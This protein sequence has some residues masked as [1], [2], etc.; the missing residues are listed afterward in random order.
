MNSN[1]CISVIVT[2]NPTPPLTPRSR[3]FHP[4]G[5][6]AA[7]QL[8]YTAA[9]PRLASEL[10]RSGPFTGIVYDFDLGC[11]VPRWLTVEPAGFGTIVS[12]RTHR[13]EFLVSAEARVAMNPSGTW[14]YASDLDPN[15]PLLSCRLARHSQGYVY[16]SH[17]NRTTSGELLHRMVARDVNGAD[18]SNGRVVHHKDGDKLNNRPCNLQV[19]PSQSEHMKHHHATGEHAYREGRPSKSKRRSHDRRKASG[20]RKAVPGS[21]DRHL[22]FESACLVQDSGYASQPMAPLPSARISSAVLSTNPELLR[23]LGGVPSAF[24]RRRIK[25]QHL[26]A[27]PSPNK[28]HSGDLSEAHSSFGCASFC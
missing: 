15:M 27:Q 23:S 21:S 1:P 18:I 10:A 3:G 17:R 28:G 12:V 7:R 26:T 20:D 4:T 19:F 11:Y 22:A 5:G 2:Y 13:G 8:I 14:R 6:I 25:T 24:R 9:G 16:L